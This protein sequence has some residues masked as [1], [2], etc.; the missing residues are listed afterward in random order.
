MGGQSHP[1][2]STSATAVWCELNSN[3]G[4]LLKIH[5]IFRIDLKSSEH[6]GN[7]SYG[8]KEHHLFGFLPYR[9][10]YW[11]ALTFNKD[12]QIPAYLVLLY[13]IIL[14]TDNFFPSVLLAPVL[15]VT[16][17]EWGADVAHLHR[18]RNIDL[19]TVSLLVHYPFTAVPNKSISS[20]LLG[21]TISLQK[22]TLRAANEVDC[23]RD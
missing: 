13:V 11:I 16:T 4:K 5:F 15:N 7:C 8:D 3:P 6:Y 2:S 10:C 22:E 23:F 20:F 1:T 9:W 18:L 14:I 21:D 17:A 12:L 19:L